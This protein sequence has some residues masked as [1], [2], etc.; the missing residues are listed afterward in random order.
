[1]GPISPSHNQPT[2]GISKSRTMGMLSNLT[3]SFSRSNLH[4]N[5]N[6]G[7]NRQSLSFA[8]GRSDLPKTKSSL[9]I[10]TTAPA[11]TATSDV[12]ARAPTMKIRPRSTVSIPIFVPE[13][14]QIHEAQPVPWWC[15]RF[16][17][18][19]DF[20]SNQMLQSTL[21][22]SEEYQR[23]VAPTP[24][25]FVLPRLLKDK[26]KTKEKQSTSADDDPLDDNRLGSSIYLQE[27]AE[28]RSRRAFNTL[29]TY[30]MNNEAKKSL[31][32]F[33]LLYARKHDSPNLLP[34]GGSIKDGWMTRLTRG[35]KGDKNSERGT[36]LGVGRRTG[37]SRFGLSRNDLSRRPNF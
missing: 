20:Y 7:N 18:L 28:K 31:W 30:C 8:G 2:Q 36:S 12:T 33:Q 24:E 22:D 35:A 13:E 25:G 34:V 11:T 29:Y 4:L 37:L 23:C 19:Y 15:G 27:D 21:V 1:M 5:Y 3:S 9:N 16:Q 17:S 14:N 10:R 26:D 32:D 6:G